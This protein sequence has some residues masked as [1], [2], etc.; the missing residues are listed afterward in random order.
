M[1]TQDLSLEGKVGLTFQRQLM[2][3]LFTRR[4]RESHI[5]VSV[6]TETAFDKIQHLCMFYG[7]R[8]NKLFG[9]PSRRDLLQPYRGHFQ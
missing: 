9:Q 6:N 7:G 1:A 8:L 2:Q 4:K 3:H 5:I